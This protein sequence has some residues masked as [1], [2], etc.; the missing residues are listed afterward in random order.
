MKTFFFLNIYAQNLKSKTYNNSPTCSL[1]G[2]APS[3]YRHDQDQSLDVAL[4]NYLYGKKKRKK[5]N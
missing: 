5:Y 4:Y 2:E 1:N 3:F